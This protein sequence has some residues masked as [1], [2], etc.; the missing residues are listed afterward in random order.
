MPK[1]EQANLS[2]AI[3]SYQEEAPG[4]LRRCLKPI[5]RCIILRS[6]KLRMEVPA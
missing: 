3:E 6:R 2:Q 4:S 5:D 1:G